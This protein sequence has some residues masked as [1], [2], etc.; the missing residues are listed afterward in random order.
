MNYR[1]TKLDFEIK[2][3][4]GYKTFNDNLNEVNFASLLKLRERLLDW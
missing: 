2:E 3:L 1:M 4:C